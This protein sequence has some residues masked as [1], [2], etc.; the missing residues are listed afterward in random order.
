GN[1]F[2]GTTTLTNSSTARWR[3]SNTSGD[4]Y[5]GPITFIKSSTGAF[6][7]SVNGNDVYTSDININSNTA[8]TFD[9][10]TGV[11]EFRGSNPQTIS[12]TGGTPSPIFRRISTNKAAQQITLTTD[13][14]VS[15]SAVFGTGVINTDAVNFINFTDNATAT[16]ASDASYVDG[17]VRKTGNDPFDFPVGDNGFYRPI[18]MSAPTTATHAFTAQYLNQ[19]HLL[20]SP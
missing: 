2:N 18:S 10:G 4:T 8:L 20:G 5:N 13:I 1:I 6:D 16:G 7:P 9:L 19:N 14:T 11:V 17:P 15:V 12:K 3:L